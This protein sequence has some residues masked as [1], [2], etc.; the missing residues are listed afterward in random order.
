MTQRPYCPP[1]I[2]N[3]NVDFSSL[4]IIG[5]N[6]KSFSSNMIPHCP[7]LRFLDNDV[8]VTFAPI[9]RVVQHSFQSGSRPFLEVFE[10]I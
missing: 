9:F 5:M 10:Y 4:V 1:L 7:L 3:H 2:T 6:G 8:I